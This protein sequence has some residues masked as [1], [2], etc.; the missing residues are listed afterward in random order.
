[1]DWQAI[2]L[3]LRLALATTLV[4]QVVGMPL[5]WWIAFSRRRWKFLVE[6]VGTQRG[7]RERNFFVAQLGHRTTNQRRDARIVRW[8][9]R[10]QRGL[11]VS[12]LANAT[13]EGIDDGDRIPLTRRS[14]DHTGLAEP[15]PLGA[16][17]RDLD[18]HAVEDGLGVRQG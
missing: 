8:R 11:V 14:V 16:P 5:A 17:A 10:G 7:H 2:G 13:H 12:P 15:A 4:L 18:G 1:V 6:A 3:S 9:E